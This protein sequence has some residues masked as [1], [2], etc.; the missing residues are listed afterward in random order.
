M[1]HKTAEKRLFALDK[2]AWL[3][4]GGLEGMDAAQRQMLL[5][6][7]ETDLQSGYQPTG[8]EKEV[9]ERLRALAGDEYDAKDIQRKIRKMVKG[10]KKGD[11]PLQ[12]PPTLSRLLK[13][14]QTQESP[15]CEAD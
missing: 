15:N 14:L 9:I 13:R 2:I 8:E 5:V 1:A 10:R 4:H 11:A 12:L 6:Q 3:L 7:A